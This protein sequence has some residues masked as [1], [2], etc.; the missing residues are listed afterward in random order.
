[1][2]GVVFMPEGWLNIIQVAIGGLIAIMGTIGVHAYQRVR[3]SKAL[4]YSFKGEI[5]ALLDIVRF[6]K[7]LE[8]IDGY[9]QM[10][11]GGEQPPIFQVSVKRNYFLVYERNVGAIGSLKG[12]LPELI[13]SFYINANSFI[14]DLDQLERFKDSKQ[15]INYAGLRQYYSGMSTVLTAVITVGDE[16]LK[17][18][19]K[20]YLDY[21]N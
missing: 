9:I 10:I 6:R 18:I 12:K 19:D 2:I 5:G 16:I 15:S 8:H 11:D 4:A 17:V 14:E 21:D 3:D 13:A 1:M 7:Y 20:E